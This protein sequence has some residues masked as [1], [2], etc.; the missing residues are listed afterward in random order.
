MQQQAA[1]AGD[2]K[3]SSSHVH[4]QIQQ[5]AMHQQQLIQQI[6]LQQ[7]QYLLAQ[8]LGFQ[9]FGLTGLPQGELIFLPLPPVTNISPACA[10]LVRTPAI[11]NI[12]SV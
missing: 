9:Q 6:Q 3:L 4:M 8:G 1:A 7:R 12:F 11:S 10:D 2:K 5:L